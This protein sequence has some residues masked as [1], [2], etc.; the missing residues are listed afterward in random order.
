MIA[1]LRSGHAEEKAP[2]TIRVAGLLVLAGASLG[3]TLSVYALLNPWLFFVFIDISQFDATPFFL[4]FYLPSF[5]IIITLGY[6]FATTHRLEKLDLWH[7]APFSI[8]CLLC[9]V[10]SALSPFNILSLMGGFLALMALIFAKT[11]PSFKTLWKREAS[12]LVE[13]GSL[14]FAS[15]S[16]L[17]LLM[18]LLAQFLPT[19]STGFAGAGIYYLFG[20]LMMEALSFLTF[21]ATSSLGSRGV[22]LGFSGML[23]FAV[24]ITFS[25]ITV[26]SQYFYINA[27]AYLGAFLAIAGIAF[28]FCGGLIYIKLLLSQATS[29]VVLVPSF[30]FRG[31]YCPYCGETWSDPART[32]CSN[33]GQSLMW[34]P[35]V[36]FCPYCGRL[37]SKGAQTCPHCKEDVASIPIYHSLRK[38]EKKE[39]WHVKRASTLQKAFG[40]VS[41]HVSLTLKEFV[42]VMILTFIFAFL[43]FIGYVRA[44]RHPDPEYSRFFLVHYGFPL[45]WLQ[46]TTTIGYARSATISLVAVVLD[47]IFYFVL[48]LV[49]II[50]FSKLAEHIRR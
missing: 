11:K 50:G 42:Y 47:F 48:A 45:E 12:F 17:F 5:V 27:S 25:V 34:R 29:P 49:I 14:L 30:L 22:R 26:K 32:V 20:L 18:W 44:E 15:S 24:S 3:T 2:R 19:Y 28:M 37:V 21:F 4:G 43:S 38:V 39:I 41:E 33:C 9:I 31:K 6:V 35:E 13:A 40:A 10:L 46:M 23:S 7:V 36:L 8:L 1:L 16:S